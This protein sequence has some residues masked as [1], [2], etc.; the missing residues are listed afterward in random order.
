MQTRTIFTPGVGQEPVDEHGQNGGPSYFV[1][2]PRDTLGQVPMLQPR[3]SFTLFPFLPTELRL[4]IWKSA[5]PKPRSLRLGGKTA[6]GGDPQYEPPYKWCDSTTEVGREHMANKEAW[7]VF[8]DK[9]HRTSIM[10]VT[11]SHLQYL[12]YAD[13]ERDT[14]LVDVECLRTMEGHGGFVDLVRVKHLALAGTSC[15]PQ[16]LSINSFV[17]AA[18]PNIHSLTLVTG[19]TSS[20]PHCPFSCG[21]I[22]HDIQLLEFDDELRLSEHYRTRYYN[23]RTDL[24]GGRSYNRSFN[25]GDEQ[26]KKDRRVFYETVAAE[27]ETE[28]WEA[29]EVIVATF[30]RRHEGWEDSDQLIYLAPTD[31][32]LNYKGS[33]Y[34]GKPRYAKNE[35]AFLHLP[36]IDFNVRCNEDGTLLSAY[37]GI[38]RLFEEEEEEEEEEEQKEHLDCASTASM[39][40]PGEGSGT[41]GS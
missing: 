9:Y 2:W 39:T 24:N 36:H 13:F 33:Y 41:A 21:K 1:P 17:R 14:F 22:K 23:G 28:A 4:Q 19:N 16:E 32:S 25:A 31:Q 27:D 5:L 35:R 34:T 29:I 7:E 11:G 37:D 3:V 8:Q 12:Q 40:S 15:L 38:D 6:L 30:A 10:G 18:C 26:C 20:V